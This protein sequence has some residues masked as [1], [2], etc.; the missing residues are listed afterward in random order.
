MCVSKG[1]QV[2]VNVE[3]KEFPGKSTFHRMKNDPYYTFQIS[4]LGNC[5]K[6]TH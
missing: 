3:Q 4:N 6:E 5:F 2:F 1:Q